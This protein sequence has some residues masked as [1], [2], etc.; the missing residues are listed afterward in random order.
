MD[1]NDYKSKMFDE[2]IRL[3]LW[4]YHKKE[5]DEFNN[6]KENERHTFSSEFK[7]KMSKLLKRGNKFKSEIKVTALKTFQKTAIIVLIILSAAFVSLLAVEAIRT[8]IFNIITTFYE[9]HINIQFES[10]SNQN[11]VV[12]RIEYI[13][14]PSY[15]PDGY[16]EVEISISNNRILAIYINDKDE[17]IVYFQNLLDNTVHIDGEDYTKS[18]ITING[19]NAIIFEYDKPDGVS[20]NIIIWNDNR[21]SYSAQTH[22]SK[23]EAIKIAESVQLQD[24]EN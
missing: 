13:H 9:R 4:D 16:W 23:A 15:I 6:I 21:Y 19:M 7:T 1:K 10:T 11:F 5:I 22:L 12:D 14:L 3:V 24:I 17:M 8:E 18:Y 2:A 20:Y